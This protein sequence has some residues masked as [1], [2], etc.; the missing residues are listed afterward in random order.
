MQDALF[1]FD[2][3]EFLD[4]PFH[5]DSYF[6]AI[7]LSLN[8]IATLIVLIRDAYFYSIPEVLNIEYDNEGRPLVLFQGIDFI[9]L[10]NVVLYTY[11]DCVVDVW[12]YTRRTPEL[13]YRYRQIRTEVMK[14][15]AHLELGRLEHAVRLMTEPPKTLHEDLAVAIAN[16]NYFDNGDVKVKLDG[17]TH[18]VHGALM[19]QRC[20]FFEGLFQGR[21]AGQWLSA[22]RHTDQEIP[23]PVNVDLVHVSAEIFQF[24]L[25]YI[26]SDADE[27]MFDDVVTADLD[28]YLDLI[29][30]VMSV[31]NELMLDRLAQCCQ[32][33]LGRYVNTRNV[34][35]LLNA[36]APCSVTEFKAAALE[37]ICLNLEGLLENHLLGELDDDIMLELDA[38]VRQNQLAYLPISRS[39]RQEAE[40]YERFPE[41]VEQ[42]ERGKRVILDQI[43]LQ[44][45][46]REKENR[47]GGSSKVIPELLQ[48]FESSPS[49]RKSPNVG[50]RDRA[51]VPK[52]PMLRSSSSKGELMFDMEL[53]ESA[54]TTRPSMPAYPD[55]GRNSE[56][57]LGEGSQDK[58]SYP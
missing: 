11:T 55:Q 23:E 18:L 21:A 26:Y 15:A 48:D 7:A 52:S 6:L 50:G 17:S 58:G 24:V 29:I 27:R 8:R 34:C 57:A 45:H 43:H 38:A 20:P 56:L 25:R 37:Y 51:I 39:G 2:E 44:S 31:A 3:R 9:S 19:C 35:Q 4:I 54:M 30:D 49:L 12:Q 13:A 22:R 14:T 53:D 10:L 42:V 5:G 41:L 40:L 32:K 46:L 47:V 16:P 1:N 28:A 33:I 36:V